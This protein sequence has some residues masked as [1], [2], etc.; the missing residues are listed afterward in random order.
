MTTGGRWRAPHDP[1]LATRLAAARP[2]EPLRQQEPLRQHDPLR[3]RDH[4]MAR[5]RAKLMNPE[6]AYADLIERLNYA[7]VQGGK[8][9][10]SALGKQVDY[11]KAT[12]SKVLTGKAMP[13]WVLVRRLGEHFQVPP[14]V[15]HE[16]YTLWTAANM[17]GRRSTITRDQAAG[18]PP[19]TG[20]A[21]ASEAA[22]TCP[23]CGSWVVDTTLHT[24]WHLAFEPSRA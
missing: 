22:F 3:Q 12:L 10:L 9:S 1:S 24:D 6:T 19:A 7:V 21:A 23:Q 11:S 17:H 13:S 5:L 16:W 18:S 15:V 8:P 20:T 2:R 4:E 14:P